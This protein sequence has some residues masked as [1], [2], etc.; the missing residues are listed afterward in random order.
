MSKLGILSGD[1]AISTVVGV[2]VMVGLVVVVGGVIGYAVLGVG[3]T[4]EPA[5]NRAVEPVAQTAGGEVAFVLQSGEP[6][7][8][9]SVDELRVNGE[10]V[11]VT[12]WAGNTSASGTT[13]T[14][15]ER[16]EPGE[17]IVTVDVGDSDGQVTISQGGD[18][19]GVIGGFESGELP[20]G[21]PGTVSAS[22]TIDVSA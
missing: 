18:S 1:R 8:P 15:D 10:G 11:T 12:S 4:D 14:L 22:G 19:D 9:S 13:Y 6:I 20:T 3:I 21:G 5:P 16:I 2:A 17:E 7:D